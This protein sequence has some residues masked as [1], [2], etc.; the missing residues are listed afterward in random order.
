MVLATKCDYE[1]SVY[2]DVARLREFPF[3]GTEETFRAYYRHYVEKLSRKTLRLRV[4]PELASLIADFVPVGVNILT[5]YDC[6]HC[7]Y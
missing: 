6:E 2:E 5:M 3:S 4:P 7:I 1:H